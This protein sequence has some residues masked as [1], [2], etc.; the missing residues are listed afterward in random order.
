VSLEDLLKARAR[1]LEAERRLERAHPMHL[2]FPPRA[3]REE[4]RARAAS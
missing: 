4:D 3:S 1:N 2:L